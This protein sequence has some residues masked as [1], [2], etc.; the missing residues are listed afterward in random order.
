MTAK[1]GRS[2]DL[3]RLTDLV[4]IKQVGATCRSE[5]VNVGYG[6]VRT[7]ARAGFPIRSIEFGRGIHVSRICPGHSEFRSTM[8]ASG[9]RPL[10]ESDRAVLCSIFNPDTPFSDCDFEE[11]SHNG[12]AKKDVA[13]LQAESD[14]SHDEAIR[15]E[16]LAVRAA[17]SGDLESAM[18][19]V[20]EAIGL[21]SQRPE[22][23]NNRAQV[24]RLR[25]DVAAAKADLDTAI[26]L[27]EGCGK[28]AMQAY[29]Q[30]ALIRRLQ[31][32]DDGAAD[33]FSR[34]AGLGSLFAKRQAAALNPYAAACNAMLSE[35]ISKMRRGESSSC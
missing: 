31:G 1:V 32:D 35:I 15:L 4:E 2:T 22:G 5:A 6:L 26:L 17:D 21:A 27:S 23:Y 14:P 11:E 28:A 24:H 12:C 13:A 20:T 8:A 30:R 25:G 19:L 34:A 29:T 3:A 18:A 7:Q 16:L 10:T 33:D 9:E